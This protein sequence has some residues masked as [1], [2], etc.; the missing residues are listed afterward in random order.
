MRDDND[1]EPTTPDARIEQGRSGPPATPGHRSAAEEDLRAT[2][3]SIEADVRRLATVEADKR[4][5]D[6]ADPTV[7][8]L[9]D[10]AVELATRLVRKTRAERALSQ[11]ID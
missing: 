3:D 7:D 8:R 1:E 6:A 4:A 5:L 11:E 9:S 2:G 10:E